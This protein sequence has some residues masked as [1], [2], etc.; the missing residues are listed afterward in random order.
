MENWTP[1]NYLH[2]ETIL[3]QFRILAESI[4]NSLP[5]NSPAKQSIKEQV[6]SLAKAQDRWPKYV[7]QKIADRQTPV[8]SS[9][10]ITKLS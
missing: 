3:S 7:C 6:Q 10:D 8:Y 2:N 4:T 5:P 1:F 9:K